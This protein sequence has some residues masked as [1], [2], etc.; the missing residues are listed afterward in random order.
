VESVL[1]NT[2][3]SAMINGIDHLGRPDLDTELN[4]TRDRLDS[5]PPPE[6]K[7][8]PADGGSG[9]PDRGQIAF[10]DKPGEGNGAVPPVIAAPP[11]TASGGMG[12]G[13]PNNTAA[14]TTERGGGPRSTGPDTTRDRD[15]RARSE[16][17]RLTSEDTTRTTTD[18][19]RDAA[20]RDGAAQGRGDGHSG[21]P[22]PAADASGA[23]GA[24]GADV[25]TTRTVGA[26]GGRPA[27]DS[28]GGPA[29]VVPR[30][31][32]GADTSAN[33]LD[34][35]FTSALADNGS[36][37]SGGGVPL[38]SG[39]A[40]T[41]ADPTTARDTAPPPTPTTENGGRTAPA[42]TPRPLPAKVRLEAAQRLQRGITAALQ[43]SIGHLREAQR[44]DTD[45]RRLSPDHP[46]TTRIREQITE[47][48]TRG[49]EASQRFTALSDMQMR[50]LD[51]PRSIRVMTV[52]I[53]E[54]T[55][56][57][58]LVPEA[59][60]TG[61]AE[62]EPRSPAPVREVRGPAVP[63][64][65]EHT[66][67]PSR[68]PEPERRPDGVD[69]DD[70]DRLPPRRVQGEK[71]PEVP[72]QRRSEF[73]VTEEDR[74]P[75]VEDTRE[76]A[77]QEITEDIAA[78]DD[79]TPTP[80]PPPVRL[81]YLI[82]SEWVETYGVRVNAE[83]IV[84]SLPGIDP[85]VAADISTALRRDPRPFFRGRGFE[86]GGPGGQVHRLRLRAEDDWHPKA[87]DP[88][89]PAP[90]KYKGLHDVQDQSGDSESG[91][92]GMQRRPG[93]SLQGTMLATGG[94]PVP[95]FG[96]RGSAGVGSASWQQSADLTRT[97]IQTTEMTGDGEEYTATLY[98]DLT[99]GNAARP[100]VQ[101]SVQLDD[102]VDLTVMGGLVRRDDLPETVVF[103]DPLAPADTDGRGNTDAPA[104]HGGLLT[105]SHP[106]SIG[107][108]V[109][110]DTGGGS[111]QGTGGAGTGSRRALGAWAAERLGLRPPEE[112]SRWRRV[113]HRRRG[114]GEPGV[115][116]V[117]E[118]KPERQDLLY[119]RVH[120]M[121]DADSLLAELPG[122]TDGPKTLVFEDSDGRQRTLTLWSYATSM[123]N[124]PDVPKAFNL[125]HTD[126]SARGDGLNAQR[127]TGFSVRPGLG[128]VERLPGDA[129]RLEMPYLEYS[130]TREWGQGRGQSNGAWDAHLFHGTKNGVYRV[131]RGI[132]AWLDGDR[133]PVVFDTTT[134]EALSER[135]VRR[136]Q[137]PP[138][139]PRPIT[140]P[141]G[142]P[143]L[144]RPQV[145]HLG[146]S[147]VRDVTFEDGA[148][149]RRNA[150][151]IPV[152]VFREYA[153]R[154][155]TAINTVH[156]GLV[157]P[158]LALPG[159]AAPRN[160]HTGWLSRRNHD[161][162]VLNTAR[163]L[164]ELDPGAFRGRRDEW[165]SGGVEVKLTETRKFAGPDQFRERTLFVPDQVSLW[166]SADVLRF[167]EGDP[168]PDG[169]TGSTTGSSSG[170]RRREFSSS[171]HALELR[172]G[173]TWR[174]VGSGTDASGLP[175]RSAGGTARL[176][177]E[178]RSGR[179]RES[180]RS[181]TAEDNVKDKGGSRL[182]FA[183]VEFSAWLGPRDAVVP[184]SARVS[185]TPERTSRPLPLP[186]PAVPEGAR[187][188]D[189]AP[190][191]G[192]DLGG[193]MHA[194]VELH[195]P[196]SGKAFRFD[197]PMDQGFTGPR[198]ATG[199]WAR[200]LFRDGAFSLARDP[201]P[202][203]VPERR[204]SET[205]READETDDGSTP[206]TGADVLDSPAT[207]NR[208]PKASRE[209]DG[210]TD[211]GGVGT[212]T[213]T[214][215]GEAPARREPV[216]PDGPDTDGLIL[217]TRAP[218]LPDGPNA[219]ALVRGGHAP[220][221]AYPPSR[222]PV[223]R[224]TEA[225]RLL[226]RVMRTV[227]AFDPTVERRPGGRSLTLLAYTYDGL[228]RNHWSFP[229]SIERPGGIG[230][231]VANHMSP[232]SLAGSSGLGH[233]HGDRFRVQ[234]NDGLSLLR[235]RTTVVT[236]FVPTRIASIA[237]RPSAVVESSQSREV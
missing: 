25:P 190:A 178:S 87:P 149:V 207:R 49:R 125:K 108:L 27:D 236:W 224:R 160:T 161:A 222:P 79:P 116:T 52:L 128:V 163:V 135:D 174:G 211:D 142:D 232:Q 227:Q 62:E 183:E 78:E 24:T 63:T 117:P 169:H 113:L 226:D 16:V 164:A 67:V 215:R 138:P 129:V 50:L 208:P 155:L 145:T 74:T 43:D 186:P 219:G 47:H 162:A 93:F 175:S 124:V 36:T 189:T 12:T 187:T 203:P 73:P 53:P 19:P 205:V 158:H 152:T 199:T 182:L 17:P 198:R 229:R 7:T 89:R 188:P 114:P 103:G 86:V 173:A 10:T 6:H 118:K 123:D 147:P 197:P 65:S 167:S 225:A 9:T 30:G 210:E 4:A 37:R 192:G 179:Q 180:G 97:R 104:P 165:L 100:S 34:D 212:S 191:P 233:R 185:E 216:P 57:Q 92:V 39:D 171:A 85:D 144:D 130:Y 98:A 66:R 119:E 132:A 35:A 94:V 146:E 3:T 40:P 220:A 196:R 15:D 170:V 231:I 2:I 141:V 218:A 109:R 137:T 110:R 33:A 201:S 8:D 14:P 28:G 88:A 154:V 228:N 77:P 143:F 41:A 121:L 38:F 46:D 90:A 59:R 194:R 156:P 102:K 60:D 82:E 44:L 237:A 134:L 22:R 18:G 159:A 120:R 99:I 55:A 136:A 157:L 13:A 133:D 72:E 150:Q 200:T 69:P 75:A 51:P 166:L 127:T 204:R 26:A 21:L 106:I 177:G 61:L 176:T 80:T 56:H 151:G 76:R 195:V 70:P 20:D 193:R 101:L 140:G 64:V 54:P 31:S 96:I 131:E 91:A 58:S 32:G 126:R 172:A 184:R 42:D 95:S 221:H 105:N 84:R 111:G 1:S 71:P 230:M 202:A 153:H 181:V 168:M 11:P 107:D 234:N 214:A 81:N 139:A 83:Q 209:A 48:H 115:V 235:T 23:T 5:T 148:Q 68:E 29:V 112:P 206:N 213:G 122:L 217:G 223:I 45:L